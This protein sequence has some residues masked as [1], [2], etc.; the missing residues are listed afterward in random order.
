M[1][2]VVLLLVNLIFGETKPALSWKLC[3]SSGCTAQQGYIV[4]DSNWRYQGTGD[5]DYSNIGVSTNGDALS[6]KL[7]SGQNVGSRLYLLQSDQQSYELFKFVDKEFTYDVDVSQIVC[8]LNAALYT[9]EMAQN[10]GQYGGGYCDAQVSGS[11]NSG[12]A[13]MDIW[14]G[15]RAAQV[16]TTHS[17]N[18]TGQFSSSQGTCDKNGCGF[19]PYRYDKNYYGNSSSFAVD[20]SRKFTVVTQFIGSLKEIRRFYFQDNKKIENT[21]YN[22]YDSISADFCSATGD[23]GAN[24]D[25]LGQSLNRGHVLAFSLWDSNDMTWLDAGDSGPC[26]GGN[27]ETNSYIERTYPSA[28]VTWSNIRYGDIDT[29]Y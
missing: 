8:G 27:E 24:L 29:T 22:N 26:K 25:R 6:Q 2:G 9:V 10:N 7:V 11:G 21:K 28:T 5:V 18:Q 17:C 16:L 15:N 14:E 13:E 23:S 20:S 3:T 12:C 1:I 4:S 19:N